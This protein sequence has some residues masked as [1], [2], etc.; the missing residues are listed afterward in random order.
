MLT[1][2]GSVGNVSFF[3]PY[4]PLLL[5]FQLVFLEGFKVT[6]R[7]LLL[8]PS[9]QLTFPSCTYFLRHSQLREVCLV[10]LGNGLMVRKSTFN[11]P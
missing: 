10:F 4:T 7:G 2:E 1:Y 11:K 9:S 8:N 6:I 3:R 5:V